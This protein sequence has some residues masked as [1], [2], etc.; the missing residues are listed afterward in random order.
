M[1]VITGSMILD[2][3]VLYVVAMFFIAFIMG[4]YLRHRK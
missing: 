2:I 3:V 1:P 4:F